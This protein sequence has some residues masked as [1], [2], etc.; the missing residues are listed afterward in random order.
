M[1]TLWQAA[2]GSGILHRLEQH[3]LSVETA[4]GL[5]VQADRLWVAEALGIL[6]LGLD[7]ETGLLAGRKAQSFAMPGLGAMLVHPTPA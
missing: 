2:G 7:P 4:A 3:E 5:A 6:G 1:L